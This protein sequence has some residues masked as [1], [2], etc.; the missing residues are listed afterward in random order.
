MSLYADLLEFK[1]GILARVKRDL[2]KLHPVAR[3]AAE[4]DVRIIESQMEGYERRLELW[5][6][7]VWDLHGLWLDPDGRLI[8]YMGGE[9]TL[10]IRE[11]QLVQFLLDHPHRYFTV[12]Q[13]LDQAWREPSLFPEEVRNY[14]RRVRKLLKELGIPCDLVNRP[15]RGYS[16]VFRDDK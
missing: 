2:T 1:R 4:A 6:Q 3:M 12:S 8:R 9:L 11:F 15:G 10:T 16:L 7:R 5:S 14:V 13:I